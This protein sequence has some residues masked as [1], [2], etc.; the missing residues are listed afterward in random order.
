MGAL[1]HPGLSSLSLVF[2]QT[3]SGK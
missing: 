1:K 2:C 3:F